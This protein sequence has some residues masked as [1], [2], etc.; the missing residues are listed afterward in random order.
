M[1]V[2]RRQPFESVFN[3]WMKDIQD[4]AVQGAITD[5]LN[6]LRQSEDNTVSILNQGIKLE[7]N[8]DGTGIDFVTN[9]TPDMQDITPHG[10]DRIP[11]YFVVLDI[12]KGGVL[13]RSA[14]FDETN[15]YSK[16]TVGSAAVTVLII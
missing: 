9:A 3:R 2:V 11:Q 8:F 10:L 12:D 7:D 13:Y 4:P 1:S 15:F 6:F 5:I 14:P 16:C